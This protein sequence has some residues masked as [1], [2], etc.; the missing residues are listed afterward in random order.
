MSA[1]AIHLAE[2]AAILA[3]AFAE[4]LALAPLPK[5]DVQPAS[6]C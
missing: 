1:M 2:R 4:S 5:A 3:N 6:N